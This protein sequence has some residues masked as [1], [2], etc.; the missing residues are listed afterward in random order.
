M[1]VVKTKHITSAK[2]VSVIDCFVDSGFYK[3]L[4]VHFLM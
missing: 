3:E 2:P 1:K 4:V